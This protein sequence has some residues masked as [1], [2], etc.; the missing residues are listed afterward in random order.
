M[1]TK[2]LGKQQENSPKEIKNPVFLVETS[3]IRR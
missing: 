1:I 2:I 3:F